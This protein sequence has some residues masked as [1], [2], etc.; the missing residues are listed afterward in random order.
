M[1]Y[2]DDVE[3]FEFAENFVADQVK[4]INLMLQK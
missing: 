1:S 2:E 4:F 3:F